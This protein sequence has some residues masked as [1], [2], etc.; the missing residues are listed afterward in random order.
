[1]QIMMMDYFFGSFPILPRVA[2]RI[3]LLPCWGFILRAKSR[4]YSRLSSVRVKGRLRSGKERGPSRPPVRRRRRAPTR[5]HFA[6]N[7]TPRTPRA[8]PTPM[9]QGP[10]GLKAPRGRSPAQTQLGWVLLVLAGGG[11]AQTRT[12]RISRGLDSMGFALVSRGFRVG[13]AWL[14]QGWRTFGCS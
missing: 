14:A 2:C 12:R 5:T 7:A 6:L 11:G 10:V 13:F 1:M 9:V 4:L 8:P 3:L